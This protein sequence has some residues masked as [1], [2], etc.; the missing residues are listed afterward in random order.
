MEGKYSKRRLVQRIAFTM[1]THL[2]CVKMYPAEMCQ[3]KVQCHCRVSQLRSA[4]G[5]YAL[6][7]L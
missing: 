5:R 6:T 4:M 3:G 2:H 1:F 7:K